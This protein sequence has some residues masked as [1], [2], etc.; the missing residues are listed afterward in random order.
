[1]KFTWPIP[2]LAL[3]LCAALPSRAENLVDGVAAV[4]NGTVIT[5]EQVREFAGSAIEV[6]QRQ[7]AGQPD[8]FKQKYN[9]M[10]NDGLEQLIERQLIL[11]DFTTQGYRLPDSLWDGWVQDRIRTQPYDGDRAALMKTLQAQGETFEKFRQD[12][13]DQNI[14]TFMRSKKVAHE[15]TVS[16]YKIEKYYQSHTNDFAVEDEVKLRMISISKTGADDKNA[17]ALAGEVL[18]KIKNGASFTDMAI[19]YSQ[20][21]LRSQGGE[22]GWLERSTL[23]KEL[24]DAAFAL[25]PGQVSGVIDLPDACY[26]MFVEDKHP[27]QTKPLTAVRDEIGKNLRAQEQSRLQKQWLDQLKAKAFIRYF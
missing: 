14:E 9:A 12:V 7:Y 15:I 25:A 22:R 8:L 10:F 6:L 26:L 1:M 11:D 5:A 24:A 16:P 18:A 27:A 20:D 21:S 13:R 19:A 3:T 17:A 23:R 4:V 2:I